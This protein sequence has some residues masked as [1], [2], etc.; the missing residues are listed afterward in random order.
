MAWRDSALSTKVLGIDGRAIIPFGIWALHWSWNTFYISLAGM[1]IFIIMQKM[2]MS[3]TA[4]F[5]SF[6]R[7]LFDPIRR[8]VNRKRYIRR[9]TRD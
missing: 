3:M 1:L 5:R 2:D 8:P 4:L 9:V 7:G 6:M